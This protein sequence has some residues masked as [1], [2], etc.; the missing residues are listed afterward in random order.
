[1]KRLTIE[2][3][4]RVLFL[5]PL[6]FRNFF[7]IDAYIDG[8]FD[9]DANLRSIYRHDRNFDVVTNSQRFS[10]TSSKYQHVVI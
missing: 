6:A 4:D 5:A 9:A 1:M 2:R 8:S 10:R 7:T 3:A